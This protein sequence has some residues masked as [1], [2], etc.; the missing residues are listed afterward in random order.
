[1]ANASLL[2]DLPLLAD[3][4]VSLSLQGRP[5]NWKA[6]V[7]ALNQ[8]H[9]EI[10]AELHAAFVGAG[11]RLVRTNTARATAV[12]LEH[13]GLAE[14]AEALNN[15]ASALARQSVGQDG[16][17]MGTLGAPERAGALNEPAWERAQN[18]QIIYLSDTGVDF[19]LLHHVSRL[20]DALTMTRRVK[21]LS[22]APVLAALR[23]DPAGRTEDGHGAAEAAA[24]LAEAGADALGLSCGPGPD[25]L[26]AAL[27]ALMGPGLPVAVLAGLHAAGCNPPYPGAPAMEP[28]AFAA[29]LAPLARQG[30]AILGGCCGCGP[31]HIRALGEALRVVKGTQP[32]PDGS[33]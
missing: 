33:A 26:P 28:E 7:E 6:P 23:L 31:T 14:R 21:G 3:G 15:G 22:D 17:V 9:P 25:A 11:A 24:S 18:E 4:D 29:W 30:V 16:F 1:M 20:A 2:D 5:A 32:L 8:F 19:F 12:E 27:E 13:Y 10:V